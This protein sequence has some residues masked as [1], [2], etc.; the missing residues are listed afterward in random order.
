MTVG[1]CLQRKESGKMVESKT[2]SGGVR[3][4]AETR[5]AVLAEWSGGRV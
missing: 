4:E 2:Q 5:W 1:G 3:V